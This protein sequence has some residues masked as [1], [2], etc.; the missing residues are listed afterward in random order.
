LEELARSSYIYRERINGQAK[1]TARRK[2]LWIG[3]AV[4][5]MILIGGNGASMLWRWSRPYLVGDPLAGYP[6][7]FL[8]AWERPENLEFLDPRTTGVAVL[9]KTLYLDGTR[10]SS[11]P[12]MQP[13]RL[14]AGIPT[15][16][17]VRIETK[18]TAA[19]NVHIMNEMVQQILDEAAAPDAKGIQVDFD[20]VASERAFYRNLLLELRRQMPPRMKLSITALASWCIY[21]DWISDL[22]VDE[23]V[24]MLFRLGVNSA[25]VLRYLRKGSD[26]R[27]AK[28]RFSLG[29]SL[30]ELPL[31][32]PAGRR[33]Y[34]FN[35]KPWTR[36]SVNQALRYVREWR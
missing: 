27:A 36:E 3:A 10:L 18:S 29:I 15:I 1:M 6:R 19:P 16:A 25:E 7:V 24:P 35:P 13:I 22:P 14:P 20:A 31:T 9:A 32:A 30:D 4:L 23:S 2:G 12:R 34:V 8:W 11:Q 26:F 33:V 17:V 21:D 5:L 28:S